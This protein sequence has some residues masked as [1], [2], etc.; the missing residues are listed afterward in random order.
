[1]TWD[2]ASTE[3]ARKHLLQCDPVM[4]RIV[5]RVG[6]FKLKLRRSRF[7]TLVRSIISQQ[8]STAAAR[9][10][11]GR[12]ADRL[13]PR[14]VTA[15][16]LLEVGIDGLRETGISR[17]KASYIWDLAEKAQSGE[18]RFHRHRRMADQDV[19]DELTQVRG[20]GE[21]T[22]QM[23]LIFSLGRHDVFATDDLG[24]RQAIRKAYDLTELPKPKECTEIGRPWR[25]YASMACWYL[26]RSL[27]Q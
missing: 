26:W 14:R 21:W 2:D 6:D 11:Q 5:E 10:I 18:I 20:I 8:I 9:T 27:D 4:N 22:A 17:Q 13:A 24:I 3:T 23:F 16:S 7:H 25:P 12:L 19:I 15:E 1:M